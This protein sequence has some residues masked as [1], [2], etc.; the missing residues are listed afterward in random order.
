MSRKALNPPPFAEGLRGVLNSFDLDSDLDPS[1]GIIRSMTPPYL[2]AGPAHD[3]DPVHVCACYRFF[4]S[5]FCG[6]LFERIFHEICLPSGT[7]KSPKIAPGAEKVRSETAPDAIFVDFRCRC[8]SES[9]SRSFF[10]QKT[11]KKRFCLCNISLL[12]IFFRSGESSESLFFLRETYVFQDL[13]FS[14]F[15]F[16]WPN[17]L[18]KSC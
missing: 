11:S 17:K 18:Q 16:F 8:C 6:R 12:R 15:A 10:D 1:E 7:P 13:R 3:A 2:P 9:L 4:F 5:I 14:G